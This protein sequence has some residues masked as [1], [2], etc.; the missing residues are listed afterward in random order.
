[1]NVLYPVRYMN[2]A[3]ICLLLRSG[4]IRLF[5]LLGIGPSHRAPKARVLPVYDSP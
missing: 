1:M 3:G 2:V 5:G 4:K